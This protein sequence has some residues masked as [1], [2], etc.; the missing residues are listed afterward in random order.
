[1]E[2]IRRDP[3]KAAKGYALEKGIVLLLKGSTSVVTDGTDIFLITSGTPAMAK[4]GSG[5]VLTG[6][7][8]SFIAQGLPLMEAAYAGAFLCGKAAEKAVKNTGEYSFT[9][10]DTIRYLRY[11][12]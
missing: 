11:V 10:R 8:S 4:G 9:P 1:M 12:L 5:D 7:I 6:V 3:V 2:T